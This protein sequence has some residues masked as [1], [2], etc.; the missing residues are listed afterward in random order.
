[1]SFKQL[2]SD[3]FSVFKDCR[4]AVLQSEQYPALFVRAVLQKLAHD[5]QLKSG[6]LDLSTASIGEQL[7]RLSSSFLGQSSFYWLG[8]TSQLSPKAYAQITA[9]IQVYRGDNYIM[10]FAQQAL[11]GPSVTNILLP[12]KITQ[13]AM[14]DL[15]V[16]YP[17]DQQKRCQQIIPLLFR[18]IDVLTLEQAILV[19]NYAS[20]LGANRTSF[21]ENW[22]ELLIKPEASL[23]ELSG[24]L[25]ARD[26]RFWQQWCR[27][28]S[29]YDFPFWLAYFGDLFFRAYYYSE[30]RRQNQLALAKKISYRLPFSFVQRDWQKL[31]CA[32]VRDAHDTL[33]RL[34]FQL[35]NGASPEI[36]DSVFASFFV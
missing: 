31:D 11:E 22:L 26:E 18:R 30:Y 1:M 34:D 16:L 10:L 14:H 36:L 35:K 8:D 24:L 29:L 9:F 4:V 33:S 32:L 20:V 7:L 2:I 5:T 21:L 6:S 27:L 19:L 12:E 13:P 25:L 3:P 17:Q 23:F 15:L 28:Y